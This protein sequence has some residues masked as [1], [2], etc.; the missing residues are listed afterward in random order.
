MAAVGVGFGWGAGADGA[1][2]ALELPAEAE[3]PAVELVVEPVAALLAET[4]EPENA[5]AP[6]D[7][8]PTT[9]ATA[10]SATPN[11][12]N[13][14]DN[15]CNLSP[16]YELQLAETTVGFHLLWLYRRRAVGEVAKI[17]RLF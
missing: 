6:P 4:V 2:A 14:F 5:F 7:P 10:T 1:G 9:E 8:Q 16:R 11:L 17:P 13:T 3:L 15:E 12:I